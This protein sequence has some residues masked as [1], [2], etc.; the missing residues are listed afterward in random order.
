MFPHGHDSPHCVLWSVV[1]S[2]CI[3]SLCLKVSGAFLIIFSIRFHPINS[4]TG[5][6]LVSVQS[7][8][9]CWWTW[10]CLQGSCTVAVPTI[11]SAFRV[12]CSQAWWCGNS[13]KAVTPLCSAYSRAY[14][15]QTSTH[16]PSNRCSS[17]ATERNAT[18]THL[19]ALKR[20]WEPKC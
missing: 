8:R 12:R 2:Q 17:E 3:S 16:L 18:F 14:R 1:W 5:W 10:A 15:L 13:H 20:Y 9:R 11:R 6:L 19:F 4:W 7:G